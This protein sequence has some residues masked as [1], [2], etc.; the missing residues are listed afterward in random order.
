MEMMQQVGVWLAAVLDALGGMRLN[1][2]VVV[3]DRQS[4][5][6]QAIC[7][8]LSITPSSMLWC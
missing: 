8:T 3:R 1:L 7:P 5:E 6:R 2:A 4:P